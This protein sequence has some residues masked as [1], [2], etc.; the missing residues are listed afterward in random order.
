MKAQVTIGMDVPPVK[1]A[2][3]ELKTKEAT[4]PTSVTDPNNATVDDNKGGGLGLPRVQLKYRTTLEPFIPNDDAW[5][6]NVDQ[7][8]EKHAGLM[9]YNIHVSNPDDPDRDSI[10][11][12][13]IYVWDGSGWTLVRDESNMKKY[14]Y[15]PS[16]NLE[17]T[18]PAD[19]TDREFNLYDVYKNQFTRQNN[20]Y[21]KSNN[22]KIQV[23]PTSNENR[24]YTPGELDYVV[25]YYD[26]S[27]ISINRI[28]PDGI[29]HY[30][31]DNLGIS[32]KSYLSI[33]FIVK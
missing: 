13:G 14:F 5:K 21:F 31:L 20:P 11:I 15:M 9:V 6:N 28:E 29:M 16:F 33:V 25:A 8:K 26:D 18:P 4:N 7:V 10:F 32:S 23:V 30:T 24:L 27:V 3:L 17:L 1:G 2:L 22:D 12:Q 19:N